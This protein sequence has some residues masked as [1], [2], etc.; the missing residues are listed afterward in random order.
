LH[1]GAGGVALM[2]GVTL[3]V[4]DT[5]EVGDSEC[6]GVREGVALGEIDD[7]L[8][9]VGES[10]CVEVGEVVGVGVVDDVGVTEW[11]GVVVGLCDGVADGVVDGV[12]E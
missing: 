12:A 6:E 5:V 2:L 7:V 11:L 3:A 4:C 10:E 1:A 9:A 8:L